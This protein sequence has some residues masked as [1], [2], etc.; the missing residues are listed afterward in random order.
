L[1]SGSGELNL[2]TKVEDNLKLT[3]LR[4]AITLAVFA[5]MGG[6][7]VIVTAG[8][9]K[10]PRTDLPPVARFMYLVPI[11]FYILASFLV[12][13]NINYM[14]PDLYHP[15]AKPAAGAPKISHSPF[16]IVITHTSIKVLPKFLNA[17]FLLSAYTAG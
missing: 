14:D 4:T 9:S 13:L 16:V 1:K 10:S 11:G 15:L 2:Y 12:G 3:K 7:I 8:E 17:C 5:F 6:D